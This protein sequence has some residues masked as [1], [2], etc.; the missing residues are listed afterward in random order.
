ML[1]ALI[2]DLWCEVERLGLPVAA[3]RN[4]GVS[5]DYLER[6]FGQRVPSEIATWFGC[7]NGVTYYPGQTQND[8]ALVPGYEPLSVDESAAVRG[9]YP[10]EALLPSCSFPLLGTGG[11]DFYVASYDFDTGHSH[12]VSVMAGEEPRI[13]Y[14]SVEQMV[15]TLI[16]C[17][18]E[19]IFFVDDTGVLQA[20]DDRWIQLEVEAS[21]H[22]SGE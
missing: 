19:G 6:A 17:Y 13:A 8:A 5:V 3:H 16:R 4:P 12:V 15:K 21:G 10:Q 11:G 1:R 20:D 18:R 14:N 2:G 9:D 22:T 7:F